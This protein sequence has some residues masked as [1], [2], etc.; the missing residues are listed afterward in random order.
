MIQL[1]TGGVICSLHMLLLFL[2]S[3]SWNIPCDLVEM[4]GESCGQGNGNMIMLK[5]VRDFTNYRHPERSELCGVAGQWVCNVHT[6]LQN[7]SD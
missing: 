6:H 5:I 4:S 2:C 3:C 7:A 1:P